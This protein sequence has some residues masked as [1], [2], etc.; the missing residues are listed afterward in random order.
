MWKRRWTLTVGLP[1]AVLTASLALFWAGSAEPPSTAGSLSE[2][3]PR[4]AE[5]LKA[6]LD[7]IRSAA[8]SAR[9]GGESVVEVSEAELE[10]YV[11]HAMRDKIPV[12][13]ESIDIQLEPGSVSA[14]TQVTLDS[15]EGDP[16]R[17]VED[18]IGSTHDFYV[19]GRL[20]ARD[21]RGKFDLEE[22]RVDGIPIPSVVIL[23]LFERFVTPRYSSADLSQP[24]DLP[25]GIQEIVITPGRSDI[26][27]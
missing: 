26:R 5:S 7:A 3:S 14:A 11:I 22:V 25:W 12:R 23:A 24:F 13:V 2:V 27:Y 21:R 1:V 10:A 15:A 9:T 6:K 18:L 20:A 16:D 4:D 17:L 19:R 8:D